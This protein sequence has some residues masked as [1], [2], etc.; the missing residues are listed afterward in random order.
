MSPPPGKVVPDPRAEAD[1]A[2]AASPEAAYTAGPSRGAE[3][4]AAAAV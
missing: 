3:V 1:T 2:A 4:K